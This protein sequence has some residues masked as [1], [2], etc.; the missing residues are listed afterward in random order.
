MNEAPSFQFYAQDFLTGVMYL[1]NEE[2]GMYVKMLCKQWT[3]KKIPKKRLGLLVGLDWD[4]M[5]E[6]LRSKFTDKGDFILN[7]RLENEREKR[8]KFIQKQSENGK[9]GGRPRKRKTSKTIEI[10]ED[11]TQIKPNHL[12]NENPN[13]TQK[14]PLEDRRLKIED[15]NEVEKRKRGE[16]EK[17]DLIIPWDTE[18]FKSQW[19]LWKQYKN[20]EHGFK[21]KSIISEQAALK[22][23]ANMASDEKTAIAI[24]HQ[25]LENGWQGFFELKNNNNGKQIGNKKA[26]YSQDFLNKIA[27][28]LQS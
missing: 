20:K 28:D 4:N 9:K 17:T 11:K 6:E 7:E 8:Q 10:I 24:I 3:D 19:Q 26:G 25:S 1:T 16:G 2:V 18:I 15:E 23:L 27:E 13:K 21:F 5:S 22:K 12:K 14:K